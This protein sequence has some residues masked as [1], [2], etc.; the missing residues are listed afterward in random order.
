M[1]TFEMGKSYSKQNIL[2]SGCINTISIL[3]KG[4]RFVSNTSQSELP[5]TGVEVAY[6]TESPGSIKSGRVGN[7]G[8]RKQLFPGSERKFAKYSY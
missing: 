2:C 6:R 3:G 1:N 5:D 4:F 8:Q 7:K